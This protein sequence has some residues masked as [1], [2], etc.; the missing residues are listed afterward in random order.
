MQEEVRPG[1]REGVGWRRCNQHARGGP[2]S[3]LWRPQGT[4]GAH[5]EHGLHGS[6][7]G[8]V[9]IGNVRVEILQVI[10]EVAHV[11]DGRDVPVGDG[12]V[13]CNSGSRVGVVR[14]NRRLQGGRAREGSVL[15]RRRRQRRRGRWRCPWRRGR[16]RTGPWAPARAIASRGE[17]R[18]ARPGATDEQLVGVGQGVCV[19]PNR[20]GAYGAGRGARAV[21]GG[22]A[23]GDGGARSVQGRTRLQIRGQ[24]RGRS[25]R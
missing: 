8:G 14:L 10:E 24:G 20:K 11:G 4:R 15:Q 19:L 5:P 9:P 2:N 7:A 21:G 23:A 17:G 6:N 22:C 16:C 12:A 18:G 25:A 3:R 13:R 1:R